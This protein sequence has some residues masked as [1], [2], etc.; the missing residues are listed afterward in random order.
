MQREEG[1]EDQWLFSETKKDF[2]NKEFWEIDANFLLT[3]L[4]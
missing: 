1:C 2:A 3:C 4:H